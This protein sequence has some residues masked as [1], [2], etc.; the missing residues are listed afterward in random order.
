MQRESLWLLSFFQIVK[1]SLCYMWKDE[2]TD[3]RPELPS[4]ATWLRWRGLASC[5]SVCLSFFLL[6]PL[7]LLVFFPPFQQTFIRH[8][9]CMLSRFSRVWLF[10]TLW[11]VACQAPLSMEFS[12][13]NIGVGCHFPLQGIFPTHG[14]NLNL[15]CLLHWQKSSLPLHH[16]GSLENIILSEISQSQKL[17]I[18]M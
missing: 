3:L 14:L 12:S 9:L 10:V 8:Q 13:K 6:S 18:D 7:F 1:A 17:H 11:T 16:L 4:D 15:L 2:M 5:M